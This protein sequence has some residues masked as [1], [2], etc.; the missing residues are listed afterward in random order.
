M[1]LQ[2]EAMLDP[3][4]MLHYSKPSE[5]YHA[6]QLRLYTSGQRRVSES[7][8]IP[9]VRKSDPTNTYE[10]VDLSEADDAKLLSRI[11]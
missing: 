9:S 11:L 2:T 7:N 5:P 3:A 1:T 4:A 10:G 8:V 6:K